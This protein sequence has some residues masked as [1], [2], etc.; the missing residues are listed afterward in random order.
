MKKNRSYCR[1]YK[2]H[3]FKDADADAVLTLHRQHKYMKFGSAAQD[4]SFRNA[5]ESPFHHKIPEENFTEDNGSFSFP[6]TRRPPK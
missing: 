6:I 5:S 1:L 4:F 2:S 3:N